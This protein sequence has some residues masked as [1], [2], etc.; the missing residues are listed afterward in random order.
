MRGVAS[1]G[2]VASG[3]A[4]GGRSRPRPMEVGLEVVGG[5]APRAAFPSSLCWPAAGRVWQGCRSR[6]PSPLYYN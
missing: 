5:A 4:V 6:P 1:R 2:V 3:A